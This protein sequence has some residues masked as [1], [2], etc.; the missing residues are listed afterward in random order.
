MAIIRNIAN[1]G[2]VNDIYILISNALTRFLQNNNFKNVLQIFYFHQ[3]MMYYIVMFCNVVYIFKTCKTN[4]EY[5]LL[6]CEYYRTKW[7]NSYKQ[8]QHIHWS[9]FIGID[10]FRKKDSFWIYLYIFWI[11]GDKMNKLICEVSI[12]WRQWTHS[13]LYYFPIIFLIICT[14]DKNVIP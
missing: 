5:F 9:L 14:Y 1:T 4:C 12:H 2:L 3:G 11:L 13:S 10:H 7:I 6:A 8:W